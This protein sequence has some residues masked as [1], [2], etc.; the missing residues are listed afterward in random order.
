M[1]TS[2]KTNRARP[3][4]AKTSQIILTAEEENRHILSV[5]DFVEFYSI[6]PSYARK[7]IS[8]LV[9]NGWLARVGKGQYQLLPARTGLDPYPTGDKFTVACQRFPESFIAFGSAAEYHGLTTQLFQSVMLINTTRSGEQFIGNVRALI[10]KV[11]AENHIGCQ[12]VTRGPNVSVATIERTVLDAI[13]RPDLCGGISDLP[14]IIERARGRLNIQALMTLLPTYRSKSLVSKVGWFLETFEYEVPPQVEKQMLDWSAGVKS[15]LV[16]PR[17]PGANLVT[18][19]SKKWGLSINAYG[20]KPTQR[21][22][23]RLHDDEERKMKE[24]YQKTLE[25]L[26][27][28]YL[29][30][31]QF[32]GVRGDRLALEAE[33]DNT[34]ARI[35]L[36]D[37]CMDGMIDIVSP[38][39][40]L[41]PYI[42]A[43]RTIPK[44]IQLEDIENDLSEF[45]VYPSPKHLE[46]AVKAKRYPYFKMELAK[47]GG[48]LDIRYFHDQVV[49]FYRASPD[50]YIVNEAPFGMGQRL[51]AFAGLPK[52]QRYKAWGAVRCPGVRQL[53]NG[54]RA[55]CVL[56]RYLAQMA[57]DEQEYW[58]TF[59]IPIEK[60]D[61][62]PDSADELFTKWY[63]GTVRSKPAWQVEG[64][65]D[66]EDN[67]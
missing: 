32:N 65:E 52:R 37:L 33:M 44:D 59:Q 20:M 57:P 41:N 10:I 50:S 51:G 39:A 29:N 58:S 53:S 2:T 40:F 27:K 47:G 31:E 36:R 23:Q 38:R 11:N 7:M 4:S 5:A 18:M 26:T 22:H 48:H 49:D 1:T 63:F 6:T 9:N 62:I 3:L 15:Y 43:D 66:D 19:Y 13:D 21:H 60:Q 67:D 14:E 8:E 46:K 55:I 54:E 34:M 28:L 64:N 56:L 24:S 17:T 61:F 35:V 42:K 45:C 30:S 16:S 25:R 12:P